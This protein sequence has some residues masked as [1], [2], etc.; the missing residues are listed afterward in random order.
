M[1]TIELLGISQAI[2]KFLICA[3]F[4][5]AFINIP[6]KDIENFRDIL[7]HILRNK[8]ES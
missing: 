7:N 2:T 3:N 8:K 6:K 4:A 1:E 5:E